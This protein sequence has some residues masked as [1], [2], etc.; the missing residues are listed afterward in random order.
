MR[1]ST[2]AVPVGALPTNGRPPNAS[3]LVP[4]EI[5]TEVP[6]GR[7]P[8]FMVGP[9]VQVLVAGSK[10]RVSLAPPVFTSLPFGISRMCG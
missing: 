7:L 6:H 9:L 2:S 5:G 4:P 10:N 3:T 8:T 1:S